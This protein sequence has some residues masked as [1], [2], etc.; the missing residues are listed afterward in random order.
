[1][2]LDLD[3]AQLIINSPENQIIDVLKTAFKNNGLDS[4]N[5]NAIDRYGFSPLIEAVIC[6]K[7]KV[8]SY[9][10]QQG[11]AVDQ[12]DILGRSALQWAVER[13]YIGLC[14][15][16]LEQHA[17]PNH[18]SVDGQP[19]L[20]YPILRGQLELVELLKQYGA[21][22]LFAQDFISAKLLGHRF[23]LTGEADIFSPERKFVPLSLEGFYLEFSVGLIARSL[24]NFVNSIDGQKFVDLHSKL[25]KVLDALK[26]AA[27]LESF[28][29]HKDKSL[30][31]PTIDKI[32][33]EPLLLIPSAYSGHAITFIKYNNYFA[34]CDR[35]VNNITD[36]V[37]IYEVGNK[38][39]LNNEL[40]YKLLYEPKTDNFINYEI[41]EYL[42]LTPIKSLPTRSQIA[43]NCSFANV[44]TSVPAM[45]YML[46][47]IEDRKA[48]TQAERQA[49][50]L[51]KNWLEWDKDSA[52]NEAISDFFNASQE[53]Q[54]SKA[55]II[56]LILIQ[57]CRAE[58]KKHIERSKKILN[59]LTMPNF[60][61]ILK[62]Y[63]SIYNK[64]VTSGIGKNFLDLLEKS[65]LSKNDLKNIILDQPIAFKNSNYNYHLHNNKSNK[66]L[67]KM[68]TALHVACLNNKI[69]TVKYLLERI[70]LDV[71]Y[72][73]RTGSTPLMYAAWKGHQELVKLLIKKYKADPKIKNLKGG[74]A[75]K[76]AR[77]SGNKEIA[78]FLKTYSSLS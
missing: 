59:I 62:N 31:T 69:D 6:N 56:S 29:K 51:Y 63:I 38:Y 26:N 20:V 70:K 12:V 41:K 19:I 24:H 9:L 22:H 14:K 40:L 33:Q 53:R 15:I 45:I 2:S 47:D 55:V 50:L 42:S 13:G 74:T 35:G 3:L 28:A 66:D 67:V 18:Y 30:F 7:P 73:D 5:L 23:E 46:F 78:E 64:D 44:E 21:D 10:L 65:G 37:I 8:L 58:F 68:T 11:A 76:Y 34:K 48:A 57:R 60:R 77:H 72:L 52:L 54:L 16:L 17:N 36:T 32:L 4:L 43:G 61:F 71:N 39:L 75:E 1:M 25:H 27:V 49:Y